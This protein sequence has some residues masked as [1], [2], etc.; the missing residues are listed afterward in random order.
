MK[1]FFALLFITVA[2][3]SC[4]KSSEELDLTS[5]DEYAPLTI[6][7]YV[8]YN[9]DSLVYSNFNSVEDHHYYQVK[10]LVA[11]TLRDNLGRKA[12]RITRLIRPL[13][14]GVFTPDNSF[15]AINTGNSFEYIENNFRYLKLI[16]PIKEGQTWKGNTYIDVT[17]P[18]VDLSYLEDWDYTYENVDQS[19]TIAG[20]PI[21]HTIT[22][23]QRD[24]SDGLPVTGA[25]LYAQRDFSKEIY[26]KGIGMI[27]RKFHHFVYQGNTHTYDGYGVTYTMIDHN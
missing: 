23:N 1:T 17:S 3:A 10:L 21:A 7:K 16:Q 13:S 11:D 19:S 14:G 15:M 26:A 18:T 8:T 27:Y 25:T 2:L 9:L 20:V 12:Y 24:L 22:V 4:K 5:I 6:G